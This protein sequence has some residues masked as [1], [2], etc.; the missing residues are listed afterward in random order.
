MDIFLVARGYPEAADPLLGIFEKTQAEA[1][2]RLGHKVTILVVDGRTRLS[3]R[4]IGITHKPEE[5]VYS[6]YL[7]PYKLLWLIPGLPV[8]MQKWMFRRL[9]RKVKAKEGEPDVIYAHYLNIMEQCTSVREEFRGAMVGLE[10]WS[11]M[12]KDSLPS[13]AV[14]WGR[15]AYKQYD[16][17][18]AVSPMLAR[19]IRKNFNVETEYLPN[20]LGEEFLTAGVATKKSGRFE[21]ISVG[22]LVDW[23]NFDILIQAVALL[24]KR[25]ADFRLRIIGNGAERQRLSNLISRLGVDDRVEMLGALPRQ[26][27]IENLG[28]SDAFV[29][30]SQHETFGVVFIEA[31]AMGLPVIAGNAGGPVDLVDKSTGLLV[32]LRDSEALADAMQFMMENRGNYDSK[33][34]AE[35][36][37]SEYSSETVVRRLEK[38]FSEALTER[39]ETAR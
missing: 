30:A 1:L 21:F 36:C 29:L 20:I 25:G 4:K 19:S 34:I 8:R 32:K 10:H 12:M 31:M 13:N 18:L 5:G 2:R 24:K 26:D 16:R 35:D 28:N 3:G 11:E 22:R 38:I 33:K 27:I 14:K 39:K 9:Y 37:R 6:Y 7:L 17:L 15:N 23:K